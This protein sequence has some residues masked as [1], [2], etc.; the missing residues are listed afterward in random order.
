[1]CDCISYNR[2][3]PQ[4]KTPSIVVNMPFFEPEGPTTE[5]SL[6]ACIADQ[7]KALWDAG[8]PTMS[9]CCGHNGEFPR[10]VVVSSEYAWEAKE[11]LKSFRSPLTVSFWVLATI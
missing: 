1:M 10:H 9:S 3:R 5:V 8:I 2:P 4:Q 7:V 11:A 6:D